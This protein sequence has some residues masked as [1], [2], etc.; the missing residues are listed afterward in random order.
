MSDRVKKS[1]E[2]E[3]SDPELDR[4]G[5]SSPRRSVLNRLQ[6]LRKL[7]HLAREWY[8]LLVAQELWKHSSDAGAKRRL[9]MRI[10]QAERLLLEHIAGRRLGKNPGAGPKKAKEKPPK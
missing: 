4:L 2:T 1:S 10:K 8:N 9:R 6:W 7:S 5:L 3:R